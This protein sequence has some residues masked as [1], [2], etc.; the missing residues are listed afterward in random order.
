MA[1]ARKNTY[2]AADPLNIVVR[3]GRL[4]INRQFFSIRVIESWNAIDTA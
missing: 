3:S 1:G 4:D 2:S